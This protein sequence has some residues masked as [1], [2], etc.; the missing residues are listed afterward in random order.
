M[1]A[2]Q[3]RSLCRER[4]LS[5]NQ[6]ALICGKEPGT[7]DKRKIDRST[8]VDRVVALLRQE[9]FDG[10]LAPG[11]ALTELALSQSLGVARSTVREALRELVAEGLVVRMPNRILAVRHLTIA[12]IE[13][14]FAA[15]LVLERAAARAA[16]SC[17]DAAIR[18][19]EK[20]FASYSESASRGDAS[21]AAHAH[22]KFHAAMVGLTGSQRLA[23]SERSLMRDLELVIAMVD[24][25]S[26]DLPREIEKHRFLLELFSRRQVQEAMECLEA[27]LSHSK[28]F[29]IR[30]AFDAPR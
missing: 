7:L 20:A 21:S 26:D 28:S 23:D 18:H 9:M 16:A 17:P 3:D 25:S 12:E 19:L 14:I 30:F 8:T 24:K 27:D 5:D 13:D 10:S 1:T 15:R 4:Y 6:H 22:V 2:H 29:V 11:E